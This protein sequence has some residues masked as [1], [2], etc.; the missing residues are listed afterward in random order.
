MI[1]VY[2]NPRD[3]EGFEK[4]YDEVHVP[5]AKKLP[6]LRKYEISKGP[7]VPIAGARQPYRIASLYFDDMEAIRTA[8][9]SEIGR[10]CAADRRQLAP[11]EDV[12][13]YLFDTRDL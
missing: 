3:P 8:F 6:G 12:E 1:V 11:D 9:A 5:L 4:H 2:Q 13:I 7:V 10:A